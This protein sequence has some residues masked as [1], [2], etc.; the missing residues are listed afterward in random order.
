MVKLFEK[1]DLAKV[2]DPIES[3]DSE[4]DLSVFDNGVGITLEQDGEVLGCGGVVL[5]GADVGEFWLRMSSKAKPLTAMTAI[6]A[7][8]K[9]LSKSFPGVTMVC[10][11]KDGWDKGERLARHLGFIKDHIEDNYWV[12]TWQQQH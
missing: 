3:F 12:Y 4:G 6:R 10:R 8:I 9:I 1:T 2:K 7:S 5:H 11:V